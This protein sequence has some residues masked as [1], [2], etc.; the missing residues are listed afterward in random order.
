M[1][2]STTLFISIVFL[3]AM[4]SVNILACS[5]GLIKNYMDKLP[6]DLQKIYKEIQNERL[7]IYYKGY[8]LGLIISILIIIYNYKIKN[9]ISTVNII[10]IT[11]S[12]TFL[13]SYLYYIL[14]P[15]SK[16]MLNYLK[17]EEEKKEWLNV[18]RNMQIYYHGGLVLGLIAV[19]FLAAAFK[20]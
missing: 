10:L 6:P 8:F 17:T 16:W 13:T 11:I 1:I 12:T 7:K 9:S 15:K 19:A 2:C 20:C 14:S 3:F 18:Y 4:L 5:S